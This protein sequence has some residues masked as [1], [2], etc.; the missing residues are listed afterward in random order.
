[1]RRSRKRS[2][3]RFAWS[4]G[5]LVWKQRSRTGPRHEERCSAA[6]FETLVRAIQAR[7]QDGFTLLELAQDGRR[8]MEEAAVTVNFLLEQGL[9][10]PLGTRFFP[11]RRGLLGEARTALRALRESS[12]SPPSLFDAL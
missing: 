10:K 1:M 6:A 2:P 8:S 11:V 3:R 7:A 9:L 5:G 4:A 12:N